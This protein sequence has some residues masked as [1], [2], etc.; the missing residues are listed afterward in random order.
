MNVR[1]DYPATFRTG[2]NPIALLNFDMV[3]KRVGEEARNH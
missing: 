1:A 3:N 2:R